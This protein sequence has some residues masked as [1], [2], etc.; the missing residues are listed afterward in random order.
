[1]TLK[2]PLNPGH[3]IP[4]SMEVHIATGW[5]ED[6]L[7]LGFYKDQ[8]LAAAWES[9]DDVY[10]NW[11]IKKI[12]DWNK[13]TLNITAHELTVEKLAILQYGLVEVHAGTVTWEVEVWKAWEWSFE[14]D[15]LLKYS[16][17]NWTAA[18]ITSVTALISWTEET[19]VADTDYTVW[20]TPFWATYI[21]LKSGWKLSADSPEK[22]RITVTY[23]TTNATAK[24]MDHKANSLAKPFVMVLINEFEYDW[25]KKTIKTYVDNC[26]AS[27]S[28][29][30]QIAD[31]DNTTV[32]FPVE[33]TG[34]IVSQEFVGFSMESAQSSQWGD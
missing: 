25:E 16:N 9:I 17:A 20:A 19:L 10:S 28:M 21:N 15:I 7:Q 11:T 32:G 12:K 27:K 18:T 14:K 24:I 26:Q 31:S 30:K 23:S 1:M 33:I 4:N 13:I 29:L 2:A 8:E 5:W 3:M 6:F 22:V 34:T